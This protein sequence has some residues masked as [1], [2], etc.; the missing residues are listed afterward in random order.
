[1]MSNSRSDGGLDKIAQISGT[2]QLLCEAEEANV[3]VF[4]SL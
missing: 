4:I 1:M 3:F 2:S